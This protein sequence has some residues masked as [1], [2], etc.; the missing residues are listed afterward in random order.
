MNRFYFSV[1]TEPYNRNLD[2]GSEKKLE[3][4]E[5][6]GTVDDLV[7]FIKDEYAFCPTFHHNKFTFAN[8]LKKNENLKAS[9]FISFDLDDVKTEAGDFYDIMMS[10]DV[11]PTLVYTTCNNGKRKKP[12]DKYFNRYRVVYVLDDAITDSDEYTRLHTALKNEI[13]SITGDDYSKDNSDK[14]VSHFYAGC[15]CADVWYNDTVTPLKWI[16]DR[17][18]C[19][20]ATSFT[21]QEKGTPPVTN[22]RGERAVCNGS[23]T[24]SDFIRDYEDK[25]YT[26]GMLVQKYK[27]ELDLLP[28]STDITPYINESN[29]HKL[30][31]DVDER[32]MEIRVPFKRLVDGQHRKDRI[33]KH[34]VGL[35]QITP[36]A[37]YGELLWS[38][39]NFLYYHIDNTKDPINRTQLKTQVESAMKKDLNE[40]GQLM[41]KCHKT[42]KVNKAEVSMR[43]GLSMKKAALK[44]NNARATEKKNEKWEMMMK[45]YDPNKKDKENIAILKENGLDVSLKYY[46]K[47]RASNGLTKKKYKQPKPVPY[48]IPDEQGTVLCES[49]DSIENLAAGMLSESVY[50]ESG[51]NVRKINK[52][53]HKG[54]K[55]ILA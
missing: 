43:D 46:R 50:A 10:T 7:S 25:R 24:F 41:K 9:Y 13:A 15:S 49:A 30:Y 53:A 45:L 3:W 36:D 17:Y 51:Y 1:S 26:F 42:F 19:G 33:F 23:G 34:C 4:T 52:N 37:T 27:Y 20:D 11:P 54:L 12:T 2:E 40:W 47:W 39:L 35:R 22:N 8:G 14:S 55:S 38:A 28:L 5:E 44:A 6:K 29:E 32:Y 16:E 48:E 31:I 21:H 18:E